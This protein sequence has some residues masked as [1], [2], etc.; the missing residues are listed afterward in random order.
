MRHPARG[1]QAVR[2]CQICYA[3]ARP[4]AATFAA[5]AAASKTQ[6]LRDVLELFGDQ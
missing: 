4:E 3:D 1:K 5:G 2:V 6:H